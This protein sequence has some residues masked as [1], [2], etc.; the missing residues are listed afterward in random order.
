MLHNRRTLSAV[1]ILFQVIRQNVN[2]TIW[3]ISFVTQQ[4]FPRLPLHFSLNEIFQFSVRGKIHH[5]CHI[6]LIRRNYYISVSPLGSSH[7]EKPNIFF[8]TRHPLRWQLARGKTCS[9]FRHISSFF[10]TRST[11]YL[12]FVYECLYFPLKA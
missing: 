11:S 3:Q 2:L 7:G 8:V 1:G 6:S 4:V 12:C 9:A 5:C 10:I